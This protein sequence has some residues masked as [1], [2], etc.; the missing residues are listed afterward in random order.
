VVHELLDRLESV[1][2]REGRRR[3]YRTDPHITPRLIIAM[4]LGTAVHGDWLFGEDQVPM[5]G[6]L[7]RQ[8]NKFTNWGL[9]GP[10]RVR[11]H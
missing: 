6:E 9:P 7:V 4:A 5:R 8:M 3:G 1:F 11:G 2:R 10:P